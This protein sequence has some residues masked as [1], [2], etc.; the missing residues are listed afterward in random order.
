[1][2][3]KSDFIVTHVLF[4][5]HSCLQALPECIAHAYDRHFQLGI[6]F[7]QLDG[8][9]NCLIRSTIMNHEVGRFKCEK[10]QIELPKSYTKLKVTNI[11]YPLKAIT[12]PYLT[13]EPKMIH[14]FP[15]LNPNLLLHVPSSMSALN[16]KPCHVPLKH[17]HLHTTSVKLRRA[18]P[19]TTQSI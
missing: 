5:I 16:H 1:M 17:R 2:S 18:Q 8:I 12:R 6:D 19:C 14:T 15:P 3:T 13:A 7:W 4:G 10:I 9:A 11:L